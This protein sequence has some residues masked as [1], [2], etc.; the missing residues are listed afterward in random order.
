MSR[1]PHLTLAAILIVTASTA[2]LAGCGYGAVDVTPHEPEPASADVC[3]ALHDALP[4]TVDD[5]VERDVD[6]SSEYVAAWG[7]PA[8]VLRCGVPMPPSY[9]PDAQLFEIDGVGWLPDEGDGGM[10]FTTVDREVLVEVAVP[11][12]YAPEANV[13]ADLASAIL[14][15]VP[16]REL[17]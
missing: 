11:D 10:F 14:D 3:A 7:Q 17:R 15:T 16:E 4:D 9:R 2:A 13:L 12:D 5:A 8:I 6:P 1:R